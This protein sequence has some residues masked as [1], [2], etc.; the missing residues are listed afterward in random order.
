MLSTVGWIAHERSR[1][2]PPKEANSL[3]DGEVDPELQENRRAAQHRFDSSGLKVSAPFPAVEIFDEEGK[4]FNTKELKGQHVV[5]V[6]GC[7]T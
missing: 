2:I 7:L 1:N 3:R 6:S 4:P 5:F